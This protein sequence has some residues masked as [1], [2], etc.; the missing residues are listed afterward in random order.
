MV[1]WASQRA[2]GSFAASSWK[3]STKTRPMM[4]RFCSGSATPASAERK[5]SL[6]STWITFTPRLRAK[7]AITCS[8]SLRRSSPLST[9]TQVSRSPMAR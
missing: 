2:R 8:A 4:R 5:R 1:P 7:V 3:T 9:K 6:A